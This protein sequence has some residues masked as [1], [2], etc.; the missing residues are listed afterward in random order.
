MAQLSVYGVVNTTDKVAKIIHSLMNKGVN[1][2]EISILS[3]HETEEASQRN[4]RT[5][6]RIPD[7]NLGEALNASNAEE[8][9]PHF[10]SDTH[11]S[12]GATIGVATGGLLGGAFGLIAGLGILA[13][14]GIGPLIA[15]GPLL[16]AL[17]GLSAG[18]TLGGIMGALIGNGIPENEAHYYESHVRGGKILLTVRVSEEDLAYQ[19]K[20]VLEEQGAENVSISIETSTRTHVKIETS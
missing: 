14:P 11:A 19:A 13:I 15:A 8:I 4:W 3:I 16:A 17:S 10:E 5:E 9:G 18:G 7:P 2:E 1:P 20:G 6:T 12:E